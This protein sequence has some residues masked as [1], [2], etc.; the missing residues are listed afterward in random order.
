MKMRIR[1]IIRVA[2]IIV[3]LYSVAPALAQSEQIS[4]GPADLD[5]RYIVKKVWL[6]SY[7]TPQV[8][9]T[10]KQYVPATDTPTA[11]T[12][13]NNITMTK[14]IRTPFIV[15][16]SLVKMFNKSELIGISSASFR[17]N[18]YFHSE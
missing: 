4:L 16:K 13:T 14:K 5:G 1:G 2:L 17:Y 11:N 9:V 8:M 6:N 10:N 15:S 3:T 18:K 12:D 7:H